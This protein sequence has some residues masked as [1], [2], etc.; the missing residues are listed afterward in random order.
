MTGDKGTP[1][2]GSLLVQAVEDMERPLFVLDA[3][4]R[5]RYINRAGA[6]VLD[7]T[8]DDLLGRDV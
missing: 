2:L 4:W 8:V 5:F 6:R 1:P 7:R 3:A